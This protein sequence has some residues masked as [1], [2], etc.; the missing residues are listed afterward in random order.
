MFLWAGRQGVS[1]ELLPPCHSCR[2]R[3]RAVPGWEKMRTTAAKA[4]N[5][6][7]AHLRQVLAPP[8]EP[9]GPH[10]LQGS[11][12][13]AA[14]GSSG[15]SVL[16]VG[17]H[18]PRRLTPW[19]AQGMSHSVLLLLQAAGPLCPSPWPPWGPWEET[20]LFPDGIPQHDA[21]F[22]LFYRLLC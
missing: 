10:C 1:R 12:V 13:A 17:K 4:G 18:R 22:A 15:F 19:P 16:S 7:S 8:P 5:A 9:S 21:R 11:Q 2:G 20:A 6:L 3:S 14:V